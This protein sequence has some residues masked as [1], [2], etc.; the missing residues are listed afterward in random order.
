[1]TAKGKQKLRILHLPCPIISRRFYYHNML[2]RSSLEQG[3]KLHLQ[4]QPYILVSAKMVEKK[5]FELQN[6]TGGHFNKP[7]TMGRQKSTTNENGGK[8]PS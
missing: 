8:D 5:S 2:S 1:M 4:P 3:R 7:V 6:Y